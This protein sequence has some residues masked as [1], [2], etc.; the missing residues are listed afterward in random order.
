MKFWLL[1]LHDFVLRCYPIHA[2]LSPPSFNPPTY[3]ILL[4]DNHRRKEDSSKIST[5]LLYSKENFEAMEEETEEM[6]EETEET[7]NGKIFLKCRLGR[8]ERVPDFDDLADFIEC[9]QGKDY[10]SWLKHRQQYRMLKCDKMALL[11]WKRKKKSWKV[12]KRN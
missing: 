10:S 4:T 7:T 9:K 1:H 12:M 11:R 3:L 6:E 5:S 8:S 2:Y